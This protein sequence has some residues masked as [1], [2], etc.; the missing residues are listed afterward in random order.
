MILLKL[1]ILTIIRHEKV[2][3]EFN[4]WQMKF[5]PTPVKVDGRVLDKEVLLFGD[6]RFLI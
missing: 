5:S 4:K 2:K 3:A 1:N 6:V